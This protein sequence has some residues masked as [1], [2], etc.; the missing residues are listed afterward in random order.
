MTPVSEIIAAQRLRDLQ[1][2]IRG[3][4]AA[5]GPARQ[6]YRQY[7]RHDIAAWRYAHA[8][9]MEAHR[10]YMRDALAADVAGAEQ[11]F[12]PKEAA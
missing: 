10:Q 12:A 6:R 4:F 8:R 5:T 2:S 11:Q 1:D 7:V 9:R 3:M